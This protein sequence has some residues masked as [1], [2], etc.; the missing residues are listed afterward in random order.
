MPG[1]YPSEP[2]V[3]VGVLVLRDG[4]ILLVRRRYPPYAGKWSIP[5]GH[6]ELGESLLDAAV[7]ELEEETGL[8]GRPLGV[9]NVD[10]YI[11]RDEEGRVKYHYVLVTVLVE[12]PSGEPRAGSDALDAAF[13]GLEEAENL[14]LTP[15]TRGLLDK[16]RRGL[17]DPGRPLVARTYGGRSC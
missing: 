5:G 11:C 2:R 6:V 15:A 12:A 7:R 3:G 16:L 10:E 9:V 14:D 13:I 8:R 1:A 17:V 4:G